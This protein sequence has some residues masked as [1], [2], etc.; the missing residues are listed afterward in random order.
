VSETPP[1]PPTSAAAEAAALDAE[2]KP[3]IDE[4][5]ERGYR[6]INE[7]NGLRVGVRVRHCGE[8]FWQAFQ[9]GTAVIEVLMQR[10]PSSWEA[11][12]GR[13]DI[14]MIVRRDDDRV[15]AGT[16]RYGGWADY[17]ARLVD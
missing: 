6:P 13:P 1:T 9:G 17:H 16:S 11:R 2:L 4:L 3:L 12:Y 7:H 8:Q 10:S 5:L 14:E 15:S